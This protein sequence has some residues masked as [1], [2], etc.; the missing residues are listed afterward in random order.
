MCLNN[1]K[2]TQSIPVVPLVQKVLNENIDFLNHQIIVPNI[3]W[4]YDLKNK[5]TRKGM[6]GGLD[7][8]EG[9]P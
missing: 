5:F 8:Q 6:G 9:G 1:Y 7:G 3:N 2:S 4:F